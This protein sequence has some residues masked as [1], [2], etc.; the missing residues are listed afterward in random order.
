MKVYS[1]VIDCGDG[2]ATTI[3]TKDEDLADNVGTV[4]PAISDGYTVY[5]FPDDFD[6]KAA[7]I[8]FTTQND[9]DEE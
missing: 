2:S 9:F 3:F 4:Y 5:N 1:F 6:F 8:S 7:G